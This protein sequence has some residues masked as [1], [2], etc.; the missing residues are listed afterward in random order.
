[1]ELNIPTHLNVARNHLAIVEYL[2]TYPGRS[3]DKV[4]VRTPSSTIQKI[5]ELV[6]TMLSSNAYEKIMNATNGYTVPRNVK[7]VRN[8]K[9]RD[10]QKHK[11]ATLCRGKFADNVVQIEQMV[12]DHSSFKQ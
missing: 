9:Y 8:K 11:E 1:L 10:Q 6:N 5:G 12:Q 2:G 7:Q 3:D 4:F